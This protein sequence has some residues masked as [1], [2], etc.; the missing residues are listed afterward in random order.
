MHRIVLSGSFPLMWARNSAFLPWKEIS[1]ANNNYIQKIIR[2]FKKYGSILS[3][4]CAA[5]ESRVVAAALFPQ[6]TSCAIAHHRHPQNIQ[7]KLAS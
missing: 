6:I 3:L 1:N 4:L 2:M 5:T 7:L